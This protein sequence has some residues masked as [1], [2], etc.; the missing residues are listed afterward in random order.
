ME[1][2]KFN[3]VIK[4]YASEGMAIRALDDTNLSVKKGELAV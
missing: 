2:I 3:Y 1:Y 4:E